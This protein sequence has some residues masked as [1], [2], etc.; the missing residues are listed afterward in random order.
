MGDP[1]VALGWFKGKR[2]L[3]PLSVKNNFLL[4]GGDLSLLSHFDFLTEPLMTFPGSFGL[5][6]G[7][8]ALRTE[9][10]N[11]LFSL[12]PWSLSGLLHSPSLDHF[13]TGP[14]NTNFRFL[15]L[16]SMLFKEFSRFQQCSLSGDYKMPLLLPSLEPSLDDAVLSS[17]STFAGSRTFFLFFFPALESLFEWL[18]LFF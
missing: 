10:P 6:W 3:P 9:V 5:C 12:L 13:K 1:R 7:L 16:R 8:Q 17:D 11:F 2:G 14:P 15:R 18:F 4:S